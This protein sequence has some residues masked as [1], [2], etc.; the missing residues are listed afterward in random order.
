MNNRLNS[1]DRDDLS[2]LPPEVTAFIKQ[3]F[4]DDVVV[5]EL[6]LNASEAAKAQT[7]EQISASASNQPASQAFPDPEQLTGELA[8][9]KARN[10]A[11][12]AAVKYAR[13]LFLEYSL[14]HIMKFDNASRA[15]AMRNLEA[16]D[17]MNKVL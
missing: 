3:M 9:L 1:Q 10:E 7:G 4:G 14:H 8:N 15:K 6:K 16:A 12:S 5:L 17:L 13:G 11:L 2:H